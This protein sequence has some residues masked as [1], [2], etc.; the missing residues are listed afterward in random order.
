MRTK[1]LA[2]AARQLSKNDRVLVAFS[3]G[4]DSVVL[5]HFLCTLRDEWRLEI[6]ALHL[7]HNLRGEESDRDETF[8]RAFC[9]EREVPL[10]VERADVNALAKQAGKSIEQ[11][12]RDVRYDFFARE[13]EK[14][15]AKVALAH[16]ASDNAETLLI[17]LIRGSALRGFCGIPPVRGFYIR[18]LIDCTRDEVETYCRENNLSWVEDST[19]RSDEYTRNRI[20]LQV[21]PLLKA[22]NPRLLEKITDLTSALREDADYLDFLA[23]QALGGLV[24][25]NGR[26]ERTGFLALPGPLQGRV[27]TELIK[28]RDGSIGRAVIEDIKTRIIAGSG[29]IQLAADL[30][31]ECDAIGF[32]I[33]P[34]AK[35]YLYFE[36]PVDRT[37]LEAGQIVIGGLA[38]KT[39]TLCLDTADRLKKSSKVQKK[40]LNYCL[41][42][43]RIGDVVSLRGRIAGDKLAIPGRGCRKTLKNLFQESNVKSCA[44]AGKVI[45]ADADGPLWVEGL[46]PDERAAV[47]IHTTKIL[48]IQVTAEEKP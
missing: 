42:Y 35:D 3:G 21:L 39:A 34:P 48:M 47:N 38:G 12:G 15:A 28:S 24:C 43:D 18:P 46:G 19:N 11:C 25:P 32:S 40:D 23:R 36:Q 22:E 17:N 7:N 44:R 41:D 27:L 29:G 33:A 13:A 8:V 6:G 14:T 1:A 5:F 26:L 20:R 30:F 9:A 31:F 37:A 45:L 4:A 2:A 16:T 10:I